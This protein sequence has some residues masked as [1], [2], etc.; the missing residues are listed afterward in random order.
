MRAPDGM[1]G[2]FLS[3]SANG[4]TAGTGIV[5]ATLQYSGDANHATV[6]CVA[7]LQRR[8][9]HAR[10]V[11]QPRQPQRRLRKFREV[12]VAPV[13]ATDGS[14]WPRLEPAGRLRV[15]ERR[16]RR[17]QQRV[18]HTPTSTRRDAVLPGR[19]DGQRHQVRQLWQPEWRVRDLLHRFVSRRGFDHGGL[20]RMPRAGV[21]HR[22]GR[23]QPVRRSVPGHQKAPLR[24]DHV[25]AVGAGR[26]RVRNRCRARIREPRMSRGTTFTAINFA[27][28]GTPTGACG[29]FTLGSCH[30]ANSTSWSGA[31]A[32]ARR[33]ARSP[34]TTAFSATHV[35]ARTS[36]SPC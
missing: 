8:Q 11:E 26:W 30:A 9:R 12:G 36:G 33:L 29:G 4:S 35:L 1:P 31:R 16:W 25:R 17:R 23:K 24:A 21:V 15:A 13:V 19:A 32:S 3:V 20:E 6:R 18:R 7:C 28:Y 10:A 22:R 34:P 2:G 14:T 5:W 27:S